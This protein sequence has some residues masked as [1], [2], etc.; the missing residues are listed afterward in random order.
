MRLGDFNAL[1]ELLGGAIVPNVVQSKRRSVEP[2]Y[3]K[4]I[5]GIGIRVLAG[6]NY[7]HIMNT[8][9]IS[10]SGFYYSRNKF[11]NAVRSCHS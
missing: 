4:M 9:G 6:S 2:I 10:K 8:F 5:L 11:L 3:L 1:V 7:D